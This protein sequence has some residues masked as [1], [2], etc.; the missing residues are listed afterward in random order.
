MTRRDLVKLLLAAPALRCASGEEMAQVGRFTARPGKPTHAGVVGEIVPIGLGGA[1][2][3]VVYAAPDADRVSRPLLVLLHGANG[4]GARILSRMQ[5]QVATPGVVIFAPDSR[6][7]TWDVVRDGVGADVHFLDDALRAVFDRY[8]IDRARVCVAGH[9]DGASY[10]LTLGITNGE[11]FPQ[12]MAFSAGFLAVKAP[13]NVRP[14]IFLAHGR[15][16][17]ILSFE[18]S[19]RHIAAMLERS[20][21]DVTFRPFDGGHALKP[22]V[23]REAI[24][25]WSLPPSPRAAI[26]PPS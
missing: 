17:E 3:G 23:V 7:I 13:S 20:G 6:G 12:V 22:E 9:S 25:W 15:D 21:Y 18:A 19:G 2:D 16:D 4:S 11:L 8:P 10:A 1:R 26:L 24:S 14:R 5:S